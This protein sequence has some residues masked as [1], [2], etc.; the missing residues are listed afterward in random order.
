MHVMVHGSNR[1]VNGMKHLCFES[2]FKS[3]HKCTLMLQSTFKFA[4]SKFGM[5]SYHKV[6]INLCMYIIM[7]VIINDYYH[8]GIHM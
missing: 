5:V 8:V 1:L 7:H 4:M 6:K 2:D 3:N